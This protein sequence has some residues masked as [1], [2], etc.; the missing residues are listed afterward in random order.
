MTKL[1]NFFLNRLKNGGILDLGITHEL[2]IDWSNDKQQGILLK[3]LEPEEIKKG[4]MRM[5]KVI[6]E[7]ISE[8][9]L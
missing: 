3:S 5:V 1:N 7:D 9:Y 2:R 4:L 6:D 8:G